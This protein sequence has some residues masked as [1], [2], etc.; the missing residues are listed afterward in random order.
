MAH[1]ADGRAGGS[2]GALGGAADRP[3]AAAVPMESVIP[4]CT[5]VHLSC[6]GSVGVSRQVVQ[7]LAAIRSHATHPGAIGLRS[8]GLCPLFRYGFGPKCQLR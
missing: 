3:R 5:K 1:W 8:F 4:V 6:Y 2:A 7:L